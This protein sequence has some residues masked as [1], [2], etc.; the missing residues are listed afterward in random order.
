MLTRVL[1]IKEMFH[2]WSFHFHFDVLK[3]WLFDLKEII[4]HN[5]TYSILFKDHIVHQYLI[6]KYAF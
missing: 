4:G 2:I 1:I 3:V 6:V 5:N